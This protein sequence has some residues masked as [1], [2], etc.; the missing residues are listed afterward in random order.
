MTLKYSQLERHRTEIEICT[1]VHDTKGEEVDISYSHSYDS[2][3]FGGPRG[4]Y[5]NIRLDGGDYDLAVY[6]W[7]YS[8]IKNASVEDR[9]QALYD[10]LGI[11]DSNILKAIQEAFVNL[12]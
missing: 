5:L 11:T 4:G 2:N 8:V 12:L 1:V 10:A 9:E 6:G 3:G 7:R